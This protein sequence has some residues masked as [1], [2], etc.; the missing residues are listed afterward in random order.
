VRW[1]ISIAGFV[2]IALVGVALHVA[3]HR[4]ARHVAPAG[5]ALGAAMRTP[6][7]RGAVLIWWVWLG[8]HFLA[9]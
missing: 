9:R 1:A 6:L 8:V 2:A 5:A 7:G 3:G 4:G